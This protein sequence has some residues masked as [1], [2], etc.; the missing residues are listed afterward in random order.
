MANDVKAFEYPDFDP[1]VWRQLVAE[2]AIQRVI[3]EYGRGVDERDFERVR[4]CFHP[5]ATVR[6]GTNEAL[7]RD[8]AVAW[9]LEVTPA[10]HALSHYF[11]PSSVDLSKDGMSARCSTWC[12]NVNQYPRRGEGDERQTAAGL[13][14]E[15]VFE[16][17]GG[18]WLIASRE[19][20]TEWEIEIDGNTRLPI[21][22]SGDPAEG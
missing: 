17:R 6:Y 18:S 11:G 8:A 13:R 1:R 7:V 20:S 15:D 10:L 14:Y 5:D 21:P 19:N 4:A 3:D 9:L 2:Q 12:I 22:G 16:C